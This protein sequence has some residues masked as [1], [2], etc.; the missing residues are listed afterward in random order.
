M[1]FVGSIA[2]AC[3]AAMLLLAHPAAAKC[4]DQGGCSKQTVSK[5]QSSQK[6]HRAA[7]GFKAKTAMHKATK[8]R[9]AIK[10]N[11]VAA[12]PRKIKAYAGKRRA[13]LASVSFRARTRSKRGLV[14]PRR[15]ERE[16]ARMPAKRGAVVAMISS[17]APSYGVP[18]WFAL[19]IAKVESNYNPTLRGRAGEYGVFQM[20]CPTARGLGFTG[21]CSELSDAHTNVRWGLTHLS[22]AMKSS[23]G[24]LRMAASKHNGG[25][26]RKSLVAG[27]VAKVF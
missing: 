11:S 3:A 20:K 24:D 7:R 18:A 14:L 26:G 19:R 23:G 15:I 5:A 22:A 13:K 6:K 8:A 27:Y 9:R 10:R 2:A 16:V 21:G 4:G 1:R 17:M 12:K 25:L